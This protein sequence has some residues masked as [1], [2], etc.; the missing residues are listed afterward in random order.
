[1]NK[2]KLVESVLAAIFSAITIGALTLLS[3]KT[4][5]GIFLTTSFGSSMVLLYGYPNSLFSQPKNIFFGHLLSSLIGIILINY[6][7]IPIYIL[8]PLGVGMAILF[9]ILFNIVHPP[10]GANPII[11]IMGGVHFEY[12]I[13]PIIT[14][15]IIIIIFGIILN[16]F[17]LKK[18]YPYI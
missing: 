5:Y 13:N 14:G 2:Y 15:T 12:L 10:A 18:K 8:I 16:R 3:Y 6:F 11:V 17:I 4:E 9:M 7:P 1:M